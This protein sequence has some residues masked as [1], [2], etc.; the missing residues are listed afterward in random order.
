MSIVSRTALAALLVMGSPIMLADGIAAPSPV[1]GAGVTGAVVRYADMPSAN[2]ASRNVDVWLPPGYGKDP[3]KRY[4]VLYMHDGQN[5]FDPA[6]SYG[7]P[8]RPSHF[9][10]QRRLGGRRGH[11]EPG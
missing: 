9:L 3:D 8:V 2:V 6:T 10:R 4:P 7:E 1:T 5:L 11:D